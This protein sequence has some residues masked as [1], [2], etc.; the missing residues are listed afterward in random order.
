MADRKT[1]EQKLQDL[2]KKLEQLQAQKK[3]I[4]S[5]AKEKERKAR[6]RRLIELG[7]LSEKYLNCTNI[8]PTDFEKLLNE[9]VHME[10]VKSIILAKNDATEQ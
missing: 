8:A 2:Q 5:R 10:Q 6:T 7:A 3:A 9:L 1:D 4:E